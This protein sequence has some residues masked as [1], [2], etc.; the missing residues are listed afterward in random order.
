MEYKKKCL[1]CGKYYVA[2]TVESCEDSQWASLR[3]N[4]VDE[5]RLE[6]ARQWLLSFTRCRTDRRLYGVSAGRC[7]DGTAQQINAQESFA[8][9]LF[10]GFLLCYFHFL[11]IHEQSM[12]VGFNMWCFTFEWGNIGVGSQCPCA[13]I[14]QNDIHLPRFCWYA[15]AY[16]VGDIA[17]D[18]AVKSG[19]VG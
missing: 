19:T 5:P 7:G 11:A 13:V 17:A 10:A 14:A 1:L 6:Q 2:H 8:V 4:G 16:C 9:H 15:V 12:A 18:A 3:K